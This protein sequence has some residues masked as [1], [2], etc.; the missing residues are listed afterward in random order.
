MA[1]QSQNLVHKEFWNRKQGIL[2]KRCGLAE[3]EKNLFA[4]FISITQEIQE[5]YKFIRLHGRIKVEK[6]RK[7][8]NRPYDCFAVVAHD[9]H[10]NTCDAAL[11]V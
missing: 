3:G 4:V 11:A 7:Y 5:L 9:K 10:D 6:S 8:E 1:Y 2:R